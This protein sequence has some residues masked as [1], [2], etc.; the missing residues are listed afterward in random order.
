MERALFSRIENF[1]RLS[2][3]EPRKLRELSDLLCELEAAKHEGFLPGLSYFDTARGVGPIVEKLPFH[4]Q[5]KWT[6]VGSKF[7]EDYNVAFPPFSF[8]SEFVRKEARARNDPSFS[9][10]HLTSVS[11]KKER[12]PGNY[13][14]RPSVTVN[15]TDVSTDVTTAVKN[16]AE[17]ISRQCPIHH[18]PHP[19]KRCR[20]FRTMLLEDKEIHQRQ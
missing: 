16:V 8:F 18:K 9:T 14:T 20:G 5:E 15:K 3:K 19:L 2:S 7:K 11:S 6:A 10:T 17:D 1:P 13:N 12:L 4:L